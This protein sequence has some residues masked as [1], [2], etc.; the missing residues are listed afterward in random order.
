MKKAIHFFICLNTHKQHTELPLQHPNYSPPVWLCIQEDFFTVING[1]NSKK[2]PGHDLSIVSFLTEL[3]YQV[4]RLIIAIFKFI[5][6]T[7]QFPSK[8]KVV[9]IIVISKPSEDPV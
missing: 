2:A 1:L 5:L 6:H 3:S 7:G 8:W 9:K 4:V